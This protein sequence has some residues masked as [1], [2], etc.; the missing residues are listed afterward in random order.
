MFGDQLFWDDD[1]AESSRALPDGGYAALS[2]SPI[3]AGTI[4]PLALPDM[5][6]MARLDN[7]RLEV[8]DRRISEFSVFSR[9]TNDTFCDTIVLEGDALGNCASDNGILDGDEGW[10]CLLYS[11]RSGNSGNNYVVAGLKSNGLAHCSGLVWDTGPVAGQ[12]IYVCCD[13]LCV[14]AVF[15]NV[16][17]LVHGL[18]HLF[19]TDWVWHRVLPDKYLGSW[20]FGDYLS[21]M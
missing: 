11:L 21:I 4:V 18:G 6:Q 3:L 19:Y 2:T 15:H 10:L 1:M 5:D 16:M 9:G 17:L 20:R 8:L 12:C 7:N 14:I 13:C